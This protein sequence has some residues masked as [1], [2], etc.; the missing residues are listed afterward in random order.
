MS[1]ANPKKREE[2]EKRKKK[3]HV[4]GKK[5]K[6]KKSAILKTFSKEKVILLWLEKFSEFDWERKKKVDESMANKK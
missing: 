5:K 6:E 4:L 3:E 2:N 1:A